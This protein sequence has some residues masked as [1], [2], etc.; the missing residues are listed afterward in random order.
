MKNNLKTNRQHNKT[1]IQFNIRLRQ[2]M[3]LKINYL[4]KLTRKI[5]TLFNYNITKLNTI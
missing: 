2:N 1:L 4:F 3:H 5:G